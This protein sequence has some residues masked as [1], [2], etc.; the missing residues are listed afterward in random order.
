MRYLLICVLL[1]VTVA[2]EQHHADLRVLPGVAE[3]LGH[4]QQRIRTERVADLGAVERDAHRSL[5]DGAVV[6]DVRELE[7]WH[8][9]PSGGVE[10]G[11]DGHPHIVP[12][13]ARYPCNA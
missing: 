10:D 6:G 11:G 12:P 1:F 9:G 4:L 7:P 5:V 2:C 13:R 3:R 8:L